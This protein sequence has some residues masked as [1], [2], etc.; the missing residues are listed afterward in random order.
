MVLIGRITNGTEIELARQVEAVIKEE[1][2]AWEEIE[3]MEETNVFMA[4]RK[5]TGLSQTKFAAQFGIPAKTLRDWEQG[6]RNP[7]S[8]VITMLARGVEDYASRQASRVPEQKA[9]ADLSNMDAGSVS[10]RQIHLQADIT[11]SGEVIR[12]LW[13]SYMT[14]SAACEDLKCPFA[15]WIE[16]GF[17]KIVSAVTDDTQVQINW[18]CKSE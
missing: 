16:E 8:Y 14:K 17:R 13:S 7:P 15:E 11:L 6:R 10:S 4:L 5:R 1:L 2:A 18:D 9:A 3:K 12:D